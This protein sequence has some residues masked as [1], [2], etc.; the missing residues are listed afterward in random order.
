MQI[1]DSSFDSDHISRVDKGL[2]QRQWQYKKGDEELWKDGTPSGT[3]SS[4]ENYVIRLRVRDI[5]GENALGVW[6]D[7][8]V[9]TVGTAAGNLPP[10]ALFTVE[11]STV[12]YRKATTVTDKSFDPDNDPLDTYQ[13]SVV[14][15]GS[16]TVWSY[17]GG[18]N[19]PP[20]IASNGVG[21]YQLTLKVR[22]NRGLWSE[23][24]SQSVTVMNHP[25]IADFN[26]PSEVYRDT[27]IALENLTPDPDKDGDS[28]S[29]VWKTANREGPYYA[30]GTN[31]NQTVVMQNLIN[32]NSLSPK[33]SISD[34]WEMKLTASDGSLSSTVSRA[35][36]VLNHIPTAKIIGKTQV[37]Q[38]D[39]LT[40]N[41]GDVDEDTADQHTLRYYWN[42]TDSSGQMKSYATPN[43]EVSF[44]ETGTYRFEHWAIDQIGAKSISPP[45]RS[46]LFQICRQR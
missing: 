34:R 36:T 42:V 24:Y 40:F 28:L 45:W 16:Q 10:V 41:S 29:Y 18:A 44:P 17:T 20:N 5:D 43:V 21:S 1:T 23:P 8:C 39:T 30:V 26:M 46:V 13:W 2:T 7:W 35:F 15:N 38:D 12:S 4:T 22:D 37:Y 9:R 11:P 6:S 33:Q 32:A 31:R 25:P 19:T 3:L 27:V 14:K